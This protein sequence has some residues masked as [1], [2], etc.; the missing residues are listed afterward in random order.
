MLDRIIEN[1]DAPTITEADALVPSVLFNVIMQAGN[2]L[3]FNQN[4]FEG[5]AEYDPP[6]DC[7]HSPVEALIFAVDEIGGDGGDD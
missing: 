7:K 2:I 6:C 1:K 3:S 4:R 5:G